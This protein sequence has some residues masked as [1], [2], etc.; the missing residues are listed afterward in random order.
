MKFIFIYFNANLDKEKTRKFYS[1]YFKSLL[2]I[3]ETK[4]TIRPCK[5]SNSLC[6][7]DSFFKGLSEMNWFF[8]YFA[9][10]IKYDSCLLLVVKTVRLVWTNSDIYSQRCILGCIIIVVHVIVLKL[11]F[12]HKLILN[13]FLF[14]FVSYL[15]ITFSFT[16]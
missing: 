14:S 3:K 12:C 10:N 6:S 16:N 13:F 9:L 15:K 1:L 2:D 7:D 5:W 11:L 4:S 8:F